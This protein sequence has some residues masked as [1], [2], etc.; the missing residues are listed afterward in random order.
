MAGAKKGEVC[1]L[2]RNEMN[3]G[4]E[5]CAGCG[6]TRVTGLVASAW[7]RLTA[8]LLAPLAVAV[9]AVSCAVCS[10]SNSTTAS[11]VAVAPWVLIVAVVLLLRNRVAYQRRS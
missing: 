6:A 7:G 1:S 9:S 3:E 8:T 10:E 5:V 11:T 2:C 4:A